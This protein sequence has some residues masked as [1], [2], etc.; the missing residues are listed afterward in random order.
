MKQRA[1]VWSCGGNLPSLRRRGH[2]AFRAAF[3]VMAFGCVG[4]SSG[5]FPVVIEAQKGCGDYSLSLFWLSTETAPTNVEYSLDSDRQWK[6]ADVL[7]KALREH[8]S[9]TPEDYAECARERWIPKGTPGTCIQ[10]ALY[11]DMT[12]DFAADRARPLN[13]PEKGVPLPFTGNAFN[14]NNYGKERCYVTRCDPK[15]RDGDYGCLLVTTAPNDPKKRAFYW[16]IV[17]PTTAVQLTQVPPIATEILDVSDSGIR[18]ILPA[19]SDP[20]KSVITLPI[21][22]KLPPRDTVTARG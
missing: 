11:H 14:A 10:K 3:V 18:I 5:P 2:D 4:C 9:L 20:G 6:P 7:D 16:T 17:W 15:E 22:Q 12:A 1:S 13:P 8:L 19:K 21:I